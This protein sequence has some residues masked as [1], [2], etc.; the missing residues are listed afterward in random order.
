MANVKLYYAG[1][2]TSPLF[3]KEDDVVISLDRFTE[4][5]FND[6]SD[7]EISWNYFLLWRHSNLYITG[8]MNGGNEKEPLELIKIPGE[9]SARYKAIAAGREDI[10]I[11]T[12]ANE[13]W[14][15]RLYERCWKK[16]PNFIRVN[17]GLEDEYPI[18]ISQGGCTVILTNLGRIFNVPILVEMPKRVKFVDVACGFDHTILLAENGDVYSMGMGTRGQLGHGD[19]EDCDDPK[20][21][22]ALAG[23]NVVQISAA[24]WHSAVVTDQ[25]D[26]YTWGWNINGELG[27]PSEDAKVVA[28]PTVINF[29]DGE[30][31]EPIEINITKVQCGNT[32]TICLTDDGSLWGCGS[33]KYGQLGQPREKLVDSKIFF[34]LDVHSVCKNIKDFKC[35]EWGTLLSTE[36]TF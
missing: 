1:F 13:I 35:Q 9:S 4:V 28:I 30:K 23:L 21:V 8:K 18:K 11:L 16:V 10:I 34:K 22:E 20:L 15:Y 26:L 32:F 19:L 7:M 5:P 27:I 33:N 12:T 6:I 2:N 31:K 36:L 14:R 3:T 25:G 29:E 24:G 17:E